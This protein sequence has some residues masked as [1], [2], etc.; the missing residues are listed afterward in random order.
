MKI[1]VIPWYETRTLI[2]PQAEMLNKEPMVLH[3]ESFLRSESPKLATA[4]RRFIT[5]G[6]NYVKYCFLKEFYQLLEGTLQQENAQDGDRKGLI[7]LL[8]EVSEHFI[9]HCE[10]SS[11][12]NQLELFRSF[13]KEHLFTEV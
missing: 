10:N 5:F 11:Q 2:S 3:K 9:V 1:K 12:S 13:C 7:D 6:E 8:T 4:Q